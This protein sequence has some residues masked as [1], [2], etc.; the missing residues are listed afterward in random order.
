MAIIDFHT[1]LGP[2][3]FGERIV[4][5][6]REDADS[7]RAVRW[8]GNGVVSPYDDT[9]SS[10]PIVGD[11]LTASIRLLLQAEVTGIALEFGTVPLENV[12]HALRA[13][14]G[15]MLMENWS[16]SRVARSRN[17]SAR[18][19]MVTRRTGRE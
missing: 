8:Y 15:C 1:G 16:P 2:W 17:K 7:E 4:T 19:S 10:A 18:R 14:P 11:G 5:G 6:P 12:L 13:M 9:S 3:G